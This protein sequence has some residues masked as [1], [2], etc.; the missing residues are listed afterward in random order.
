MFVLFANSVKSDLEFLLQTLLSSSSDKTV[1]LWKIGCSQCLSVFYHKDYGKYYLQHMPCSFSYFARM[2]NIAISLSNKYNNNSVFFSHGNSDL[3]SIQPC[4]WKLLHQ[5]FHRRQSPNMGDTW[6]T[7][8][9]LG[10]HKRCDKCYKLPTRCK[11]MLWILDW[12]SVTLYFLLVV[13]ITILDSFLHKILNLWL[14]TRAGVCS[15]FPHRHL[16][17]LCCLRY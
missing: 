1:R 10:R 2:W 16:P 12:I 8:C 13:T 5:W 9:W 11:S 3:Y 6:R 15:R 4:W 17:F 14:F 7:S